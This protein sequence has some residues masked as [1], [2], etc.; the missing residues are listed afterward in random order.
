MREP[1][2]WERGVLQLVRVW[3]PERNALRDRRSGRRLDS[4]MTMAV[5]EG[6]EIVVEVQQLAACL[7][8]HVAALAPHSAMDRQPDG[9]AR[10][11]DTSRD[12]LGPGGRSALGV[13]K[14]IR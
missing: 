12:R 4:G 8:G 9:Q 5:D 7:V 11:A 1:R 14:L 10:S 2:C 3:H 13:R 6:G